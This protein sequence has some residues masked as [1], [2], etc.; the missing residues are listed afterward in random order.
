MKKINLVILLALGAVLLSAC[1]G[2]RAALVNT[3][4]G[5]AADGE[6]A[7]LSSGSHV[8]AVDVQT[9][10]EVWRY[11]AETDNNIIFYANPV[12]TSD[13]QL[14]V[15]SGR[16]MDYEALSITDIGDMGE[17]FNR[18]NKTFSRLEPTLYAKAQECS[19]T[20]V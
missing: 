4:A 17:Q 9:G 11:P 7:Y 16:R 12:L 3:W 1:T 5:L 15:G 18:V 8:Y 10:K 2:G 13:G 19:I 14:L 20:A 6:R